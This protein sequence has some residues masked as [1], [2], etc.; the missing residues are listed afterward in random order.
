MRQQ[1]I[2]HSVPSRGMNSIHSS[3]SLEISNTSQ[4]NDPLENFE[5][6]QNLCFSLAFASLNTPTLIFDIHSTKFA[7]GFLQGHRANF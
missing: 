2:F 4:K 7:V 1:S 6:L 3:N 5:L